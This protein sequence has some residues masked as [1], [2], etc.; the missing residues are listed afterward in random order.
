[1]AKLRVTERLLGA[2]DAV[3][4]DVFAVG[5]VL[6]FDEFGLKF[7]VCRLYGTG[8]VVYKRVDSRDKIGDGGKKGLVNASRLRR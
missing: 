8:D 1:M 2:V 7:C 4:G 5:D 6:T 3:L